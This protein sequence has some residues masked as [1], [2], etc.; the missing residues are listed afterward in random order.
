MAKAKSKSKDAA[1]AAVTPDVVDLVPLADDEVAV[2]QLGG[3]VLGFFKGLGKFLATA[4][5]LERHAK[6]ELE[7]AKLLK[8]STTAAEDVAVQKVVIAAADDNKSVEAHW[9]PVTQA[10]YRLHKTMTG[11]RGRAYD[12][13]EERRKI[14][15]RLHDE[16][17]QRK[18]REARELEESNRRAEEARQQAQRDRELEEAEAEAVKRERSSKDLSAREVLFVD[19]VWRGAVPQQAA[20]E[21]GYKNPKDAGEFLMKSAK[22]QAAIDG[23]RAAETIRE[24]A[25][26]KAQ[27]PLDVQVEEVKADIERASGAKDTTRHSAEI[28]DVEKLIAACIQGGHG[29]PWDI[30]DVKPAK[31]NEYAKGLKEKI[32]AWPGVRYK[33]ETGVSR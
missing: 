17:V 2:T 21:V 13:N 26:A 29:I 1:P 33:K 19:K 24:Q 20:K 8:P 6:S 5:E 32:N 9:S 31:V 18:N 11:A 3:L 15:N 16:Y 4:G 27:R 10:F 14:G 22:I 25:A 28:V 23:K 30:L 12:A 7:A